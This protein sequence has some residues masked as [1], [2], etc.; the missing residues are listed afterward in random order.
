MP[1]LTTAP[2]VSQSLLKFSGSFSTSFSRSPSTRPVTPFLMAAR[3]GLSWIISRE[4]LRQVGG[5]DKPAHE[6]EIPRQKLGFVGDEHALDVELDASLAVG[7]E[8]IE[9]PRA[10]H[11]EEGGVF[12][13]AFRPV[14]DGERGLVEQSGEAAV[15]VGVVSRADIGLGLGPQRRAVGDLGRLRA[16]L[17]DYCDRHRHM[18][19]LRLDDPL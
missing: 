1:S 11:E 13:A 16:G 3:R 15:E 5:I 6:T 17:L 9:R 18:A 2:K 12:V 7:V 10:R 8:Q 14:V 19:G 4:T